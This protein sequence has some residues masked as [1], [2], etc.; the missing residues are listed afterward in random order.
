V[1]I[2]ELKSVAVVGAGSMGRQIAL[3]TALHGYP[4]RLW[5][6]SAEQMKAA[7]GWVDEY[8]A[9]RLEKGRWTQEQATR[10]KQNLAFAENL[11]EACAEADLAIEAVVEDVEVK[12]AVF[13]DLDELCPPRTILATNSSTIVSSR[14]A[15][16]TSRAAQVANMHYF[17]PAMVMEVV[18]VVQG[19]HT[20]AETAEMLV[21]FCRRTGK[22][23]IW[24]KREI[25]GF[26]ANR[27]LG[28][29]IREAGRLVDEGYASFE[30][31]D[32]A[33]EKALG[34]PMG[35]FRLL[36]MTG[37]DVSYLVS[38][39]RYKRTGKEED[40]PARCIEDRVKSGHLGRKTGQGF[41]SYRP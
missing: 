8:V 25:D 16:A 22:K 35:P 15:D 5:D 13:G 40:K 36:D 18:E 28:A 21:E 14:L 37:I 32:L 17:N 41:Y 39:D 3:N 38:Q 2:D 20:S 23:P 11:A 12:R 26:I 29:V 24:M 27:L 9:G 7:R 33:A 34:H 6:S 19:P 4:V 10:A 1:K 30:E 31:V